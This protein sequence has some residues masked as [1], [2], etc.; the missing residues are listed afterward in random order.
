MWKCDKIVKLG[1]LYCTS[2]FFGPDGKL[3]GKHRKLKPTGTER[4]IW[5]EGD[6]STLTVIQTPSYRVKFRVIE[7]EKR[8]NSIIF[9]R[10]HH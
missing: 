3:I 10:W 7:N 8:N 2:L 5:G 4:V 6:A 9:G 1:T